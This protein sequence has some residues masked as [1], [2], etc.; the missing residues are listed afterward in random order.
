MMHFRFPRFQLRDKQDSSIMEPTTPDSHDNPRK[1]CDF[2]PQSASRMMIL[3]AARSQHDSVV[4]RQLHLLLLNR[5]CEF[6]HLF[7][8]IVEC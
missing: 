2:M 1:P 4:E 8:S 3:A 5:N 6:S 7:G